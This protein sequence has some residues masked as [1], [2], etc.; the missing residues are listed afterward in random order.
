MAVG[1]VAPHSAFSSIAPTATLRHHQLLLTTILQANPR[2]RR[3]AIPCLTEPHCRSTMA[4]THCRSTM[5][6]A[7]FK[8][9]VPP[10][11]R[12]SLHPHTP[13]PNP[14]PNPPPS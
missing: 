5:A 13:L 8:A 11:L 4:N 7:H 1:K 3:N 9:S 12:H 10:P 14:F 6:S 2:H